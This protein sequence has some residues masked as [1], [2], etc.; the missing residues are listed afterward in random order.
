MRAIFYS[1]H[2]STELYVVQTGGKPEKSK[3]AP[4]SLRHTDPW[5]CRCSQAGW[6]TPGSQAPGQSHKHPSGVTRVR[7]SFLVQMQTRFDINHLTLALEFE[8]KKPERRERTA[9]ISL[10]RT[11]TVLQCSGKVKKRLGRAEDQHCRSRVTCP[12][13]HQGVP[14]SVPPVPPPCCTGVLLSC[15]SRS[16]LCIICNRRQEKPPGCP[17]WEE[18]TG[19]KFSPARCSQGASAASPSAT[20]ALDAQRGSRPEQRGLTRAGGK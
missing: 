8:G 13:L 1:S 15:G 18:V 10:N 6:A 12:T 16:S 3:Q 14:C 4:N 20:E 7:N 11:R 19:A 9:G 17:T 2:I 5:S